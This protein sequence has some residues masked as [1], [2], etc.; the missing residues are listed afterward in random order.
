M[1]TYEQLQRAVSQNQEYSLVLARLYDKLDGCAHLIV[2]LNIHKFW[3]EDNVHT[4]HLPGIPW[5]TPEP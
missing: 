5:P 1:W 4:H 3:D 2:D